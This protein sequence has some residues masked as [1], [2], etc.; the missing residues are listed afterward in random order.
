MKTLNCAQGST[1]WLLARAGLVTAS[2][3]DELLTP[4]FAAR[5]GEGIRTFHFK[6]LAERIMG[7]QSS[8]PSGGTW[9]MEAGN[10]LEKLARPWFSFDSGMEVSTAGLVISDDGKVGCSPDGLIGE[11]GGLEIK[12]PQPAAHLR[13]LADGVLP[14]EYRAQVHFSMYVTGRKWWKFVSYH[15]YLPR[16]VVHVDRDEEIQAAIAAAVSPFV[17]ALDAAEAR[18]REQMMPKDYSL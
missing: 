17:A 4:E 8:G 9:A 7:P 2:E 6:K 15:T 10:I 3:A 18:V 16:L 5:K 14:K 1:E 11:D 13:Y 12:C